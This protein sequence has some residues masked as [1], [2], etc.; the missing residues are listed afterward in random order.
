V[1]PGSAVRRADSGLNRMRLEKSPTAII[2]LHERFSTQSIRADGNSSDRA[3]YPALF[4]G[5]LDPFVM[6]QGDNS[7]DCVLS[8]Q[9]SKV[10]SPQSS[11]CRC[12]VWPMILQPS[13]IGMRHFLEAISQFIPAKLMTIV[14][15]FVANFIAP[16]AGLSL[17]Q[18]LQIGRHGSDSIPIQS[19]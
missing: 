18:M 17:E 16:R 3:S 6:H 1:A 2:D 5:Y 13:Q 7:Q 11:P 15:D 12:G 9:L 4:S 14:L 10:H 19:Q 8:G